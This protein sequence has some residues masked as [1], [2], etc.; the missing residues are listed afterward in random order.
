MKPK[1]TS[2]Q[3]EPVSSGSQGESPVP[4]TMSPTDP[5]YAF[6]VRDVLDVLDRY[7]LALGK[8]DPTKSLNE[9]CEDLLGRMRAALEPLASSDAERRADIPDLLRRIDEARAALPPALALRASPWPAA[10]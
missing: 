5:V 3:N 9:D 10:V 2:T 4:P 6:L 7:G 1:M 8:R